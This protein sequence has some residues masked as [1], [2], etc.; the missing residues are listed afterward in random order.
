MSLLDQAAVDLRA[1]LGDSS[2]GFAQPIT[3]TNPEGLSLEITGLVKD[4]S[5]AI[6]PDTG[7]QVMARTASVALDMA[8][9]EAAGLGEPRGIADSGKRPWLV[10]FKDALGATHRFKVSHAMPDHT[11]GVVTCALE[12]YRL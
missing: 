4:V 10:E 12:F 2:G 11:L 3:V 5:L 1:I 9:L 6:D 8:A 7:Q